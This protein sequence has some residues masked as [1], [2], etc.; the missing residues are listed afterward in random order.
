MTTISGLSGVAEPVEDE[1]LGDDISDSFWK[2]KS[3]LYAS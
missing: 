3:W 1:E 2:K